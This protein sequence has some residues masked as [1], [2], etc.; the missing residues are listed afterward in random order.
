MLTV[1]R[2]ERLT[3][4]GRYGDGRGLCLQLTESGTKSWLFRYERSG[5]ERFMGLGAWPDVKLE[6]AR[7]RARKARLLLLDGIDPLEARRSEHAAR[8]LDEAKLITFEAAAREYFR[9]HEARWRN[10]KH[11]AQFLSTLKT[12]A[13]PKIGR[14]SVAAIDTASVLRVLEQPYPDDHGKTLWMAVPETANRVRGRIEAV[15][16]WSAVRGYRTGDTPA[17]WKGHLAEVLP[18]RAKIQR[19]RHHPALPF[20]ELPAFMLAL[21]EREGVAARAL[22]WTILTAARTG[23]TIGAA[24]PEIDLVARV[25]T[26]PA[27][28]IKGGKEHRV[29]LSERAVA[30]LTALPREKGNDFVF[31]GPKR[32]GGLS[33]MAMAA[34]LS[35]MGRKDITVHGFRSTFRDWA[36]ERTAYPNHVVEMALAHTVGNAVERAYRRGDLFEKRRRLMSEWSKY[37]SSEPVKGAEVVALRKAG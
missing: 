17:R 7:E 19:T 23:E 35:R 32:G 5:R 20:A 33:N 25:W 15:L 29:P 11:A 30:L 6:D 8:A 21:A 26:I 14:L 28:R 3:K 27:G 22:E 9:Q 10:V 13:F 4:P 37:A 36:A 12:Y 1:K 24:W 34:V 16:D 31:I 18:P 2:I